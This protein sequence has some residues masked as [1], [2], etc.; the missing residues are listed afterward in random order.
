MIKSNLGF[1]VCS[2]EETELSLSQA[3][4]TDGLH[5]KKDIR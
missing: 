1:Q 3:I 4:Y 5:V 2:R